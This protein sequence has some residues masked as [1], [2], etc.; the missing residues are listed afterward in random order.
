M[1][2]AKFTGSRDVPTPLLDSV[3]KAVKEAGDRLT[4]EDLPLI[5]ATRALALKI[6]VADLYFEDLTREAKKYNR[7]PPSMDN[8]SHTQF[9]RYLQELGFTPVAREKSDVNASKIKKPETG[10]AK[11]SRLRSVPKPNAG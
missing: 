1:P 10:S 8:A 5:Y 4:V 11:L 3:N 2:A 7:V 9:L 6:D